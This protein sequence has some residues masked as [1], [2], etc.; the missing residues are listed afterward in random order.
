MSDLEEIFSSET[1]KVTG[2]D[3]DGVETHPVNASENGEL[4]AV[5]TSNH[6]WQ[7]KL[8]TIPA[9]STVELK[10]GTEI[11]PNRKGVLFQAK[12]RGL[13]WG[14]ADNFTPFE[15]FKSQFFILPY[16]EGSSIFIENT[17]S[18]DGYMAIGEIA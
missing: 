2:S 12:T 7:S 14:S 11:L 8:L 17:K 4:W 5:D 3:A 6:G 13:R 1:V 16:G 15:A 18:Y 10:V 9:N